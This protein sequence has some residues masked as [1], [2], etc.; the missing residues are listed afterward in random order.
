MVRELSAGKLSSC[1]GGIQKSGALIHLL[2]P[3]VRALPVGRL[4]SGKEGAQ[5]SGSQL[6]LLAED[7]C[8]MGPCPRKSLASVAHILSND[9]EVLGLLAIL[10]HGKSSGALNTLDGVHVKDGRAILHRNGSQPLV[11]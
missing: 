10:W 9:H 6:C 2:I 1:R 3:G 8:L 7:E 4:S 5:V 11:R